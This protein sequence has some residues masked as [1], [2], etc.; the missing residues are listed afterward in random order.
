MSDD[1]IV[2]FVGLGSNLDDPCE[3]VRRALSELADIPA[4]RLLAHSSLYRSSPMGPAEQPDFINAVAKIET[5]LGPREL[6]SE[7][8]SIEAAHRRKR[9]GERW[10]PRTLDLDLLLYG[11]AII[12]ETDLEVPHAG[13]AERNF[14]LQPLS[15]IDAEIEIPGRGSVRVLLSKCPA[16]GLWRL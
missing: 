6:L 7:L 10:G 1:R 3:Q 5:G 12:R 16:A 11:T 2:A 4:T 13:L 8:Q 9:D 14:V 15:E